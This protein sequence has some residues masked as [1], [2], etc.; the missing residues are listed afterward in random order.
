[1]HVI[2]KLRLFLLII[3]ILNERSPTWDIRFQL[4]S[5]TENH[6]FLKH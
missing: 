4:Q 1:M 6:S 3:S 5:R 2:V